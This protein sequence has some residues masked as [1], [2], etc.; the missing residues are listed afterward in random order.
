MADFTP[1]EGETKMNDIL[2]GKTA[3]PTSL[4]VILISNTPSAIN[5]LGEGL[6]YLDLTQ[7]T[8]FVGGDDKTLTPANWVS[9]GGGAPNTYPQL[10]F[11]ADTG[12]ASDVSGYALVDSDNVVWGVGLNAEVESTGVLKT[13][14]AGAVYRVNP[15]LGTS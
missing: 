15:Q 6:T 1:N 13:M 2:V 7:A 14:N 4:R 12:G 10:E 5:T 9:P 11:T 8:G 3:F